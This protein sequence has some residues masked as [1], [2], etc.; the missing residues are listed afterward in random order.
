MLSWNVF[1]WESRFDDYL[2]PHSTVEDWTSV[3]RS[4]R[5]FIFDQ[6]MIRLGPP[7]DSGYVVPAEV[8]RPGGVAVCIGVGSPSAIDFDLALAN[9]G[10]YV[11]QFDH[12]IRGYNPSHASITFHQQGI[13]WSHSHSMTTLDD[14]I[15]TLLHSHPEIKILKIDVEGDEWGAFAAVHPDLLRYVRTIVC[16][17]HWLRH[18]RY[19]PIAAMATSIMEKIAK[20]HVIV[21][22]HPNN[23]K[24]PFKLHDIEFPNVLEVTFVN[25]TMMNAF[26]PR[27]GAVTD[28]LDY[29]SDPAK[30]EYTMV[31]PWAL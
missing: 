29:P 3:V 26:R 5:P 10:L 15:E 16:E 31:N 25:R 22:L 6:P 21:R 12:M 19:A 23:I 4:F 2:L 11:S 20:T 1:S 8:V 18:C 24:A 7:H 13:G 28:H 9:S 30:P 27:R 17:F 14:V